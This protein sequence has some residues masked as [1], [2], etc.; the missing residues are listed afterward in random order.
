MNN[1][2]DKPLNPDEIIVRSIPWDELKEELE[3]VMAELEL[4]KALERGENII[5]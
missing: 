5:Q 2:K 1:M 4:R 3:I